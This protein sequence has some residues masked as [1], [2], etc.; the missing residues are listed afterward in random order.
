MKQ[1]HRLI[2]LL[3]VL[4]PA[5]CGNNPAAQKSGPPRRD[6]G[7]ESQGHAQSETIEAL[8]RANRLRIAAAADLRFAL[9]ELIAAFERMHPGATIE[10][11]YGSSGNFF[12][13]L[14]NQAPFDLFLSADIDYPKRLVEQ[15][16]GSVDGE[17]PYATGHIVLWAPNA[18]SLDVEQGGLPVVIDE[19]VKKIAIANPNTAPYG[20]AAVAALKSLGVYEAVESKLVYGENVAQAAQMVESGAAD[21][22]IIALS[23]A[24]SPAMR[25][26]G[27][28]WPI[29]ENAHPPI[30]QGGVVLSWALD[31][32]LARA[33]RD[34]LLSGG[35]ASIL[36][37]F[38]FE[39]AGG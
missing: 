16:H 2:A 3:L 32:N 18:S 14:A 35:G 37:R 4:V 23:L 22:G 7:D 15:R 12:S 8:P 5:G 33:F 10:A 26:K 30:V 11:T 24:V 21:L 34:Y 36:R 1:A 39:P 28:Y 31:A 20:R 25:D 27:R 9:P 19:A 13:Q 17:F 6:T 38:G 29:P